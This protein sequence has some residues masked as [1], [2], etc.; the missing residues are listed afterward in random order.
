MTAGP[1]PRVAALL[2][3]LRPAATELVVALDDRA[4]EATERAIAAVADVVVRYPYR[5]PV[6]RPLRWLFARCQ[7]DWI[8]NVD[9]DEI[10]GAELLA[11]LPTLVRAEDVTHYWLLRRWLWPDEASVIAEHP[12]STDYQL[13]LVRNDPLLLSFPSET[14]RPLEATGPH[15]FLRAPLYHADLLLSPLERREAKARR[16]EALRPGKRV[17]GMPMNYMFLPERRPKLATEPLPEG[18][19]ELVRAVLRGTESGSA[20]AAT[21][22]A[23]AEA[24]IDRLWAGR[25]LSAADY[26][27]RIELLDAPARL[28]ESEQRTIDVV[29]TNL[30]GVTWAA[31]KGEPE[32]RVSYHWLGVGGDVVTHGVQT[33]LPAA[34][35]PGESEVVPLHVL[36]PPTAGGYTLRVD[37]V[38]EQVRWFGC[39]VDSSWEVVPRLRV[40][41]VGDEADVGRMLDQLA[42]EAPSFEPLVLSSRLDP[43][44]FGP[45]R[46]PDLREYLLAGTSP[47]RR[48]DWLVILMRSLA[49]DR[50]A[51]GLRAEETRP[52]GRGGDAFLEALD[53]CT[54]LLRVSDPQPGLRERWLERMTLRA[55]RRLGVAVVAGPGELGLH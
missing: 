16:Y 12:W 51:K 11:A 29:V 27:A 9:D 41:L 7:G 32:I 26:R 45:P 39:D 31:G 18:D 55:A 30:G 15:R 5:E 44:R 22:S 37:L 2:E 28:H 35:A 3:L 14:H 36:A 50:A 1:G 46:A 23:A 42:Q 47:G 4:D 54:H 21:V 25:E 17:G 53:G 33:H 52:L 8:F 49:L 48:R 24:E 34:L 13:R 19:V 40:A 38:H 20:P 6:D 10:P 43:P